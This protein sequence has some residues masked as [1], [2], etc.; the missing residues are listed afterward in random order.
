M[1]IKRSFLALAVLGTVMPYTVF[2]MWLVKEGFNISLFFNLILT[3]KVS[4][5]AWLDVILS[6][7]TLIVLTYYYRHFLGRKNC[8]GIIL[9]TLIFGVSCG[10]PFFAYVWVSKFKP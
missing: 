7:I 9:L 8:T 2:M 1:N 3:N 5:F 10:L 6:A 4:L